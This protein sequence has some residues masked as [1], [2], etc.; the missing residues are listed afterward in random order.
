MNGT[1][2]G[3]EREGARAWLGIRYARAARFQP[4]VLEPFDPAGRYDAY[5]TAPF[6]VP[7]E[8]PALDAEPG[9][10]CHVLNVWAP[11]EPADEPL[12][13]YVSVYGG[14]FEQGAGSAW[15]QDGARLAAAGGMVV[16]SPNY[17]VGALGFL[18]LSRYGGPLAQATNLGLQDLVAA[19]RWVR[20]HIARFGGD[21]D[22]V[23]VVGES[24]GGFLAA[25][26][27]AVR[28]A[29]GLYA[30]LS[31]H[32][33]AASRIVPAERA[34]AMAADLLDVLGLADDPHAL[35]DVPAAD[36]VRAQGRIVSTDIGVRNGPAPQ[37]FGVV[38]DSGLPHGVLA[39]HPAAA[40]AT[41]RARDVHLL[42][43]ATQD[44]IAGFRAAVPAQFDPGALAEVVA[45]V[46]SWG[47]DAG[48]AA[49]VV[50]HY[51]AQ[52]GAGATPGDVRE[53]LLSDYVYRLP[54]AR[55]A[56]TQAAAGG[57]AH[58]LM[59]GGADG[60]PAAHSCAAAGLV[61]RHMP[62]ST[63][64]ADRRDDALRDV[65]RAYITGA[66]LP[67][68]ACPA[69]GLVAHG[70]GE[71]RVPASEAFAATLAVWDGVPRP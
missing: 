26:L 16:V 31:V 41:G 10:D 17:R 15:S 21:P 50:E 29:D 49:D 4:P 3:T 57:R 33:A 44:E 22:R 40:F 37:A 70:I 19:L 67:W 55:L 36:L 12:P 62:V 27:P 20:E 35:V 30:Q 39:E 45:E 46:T 24:A 65:L 43:S 64:A 14:G 63:P 23:T 18:A 69:D 1:G 8:M 25:A 42:V 61:G 47:V 5:G 32:S 13:V 60:Q 48:R 7:P 54:V 52:V 6:Q 56:R 9:E 34:A 51:R 59:I 66:P 11:P 28:A 2:T 53:R 71:L 58:L 38:D 68:P